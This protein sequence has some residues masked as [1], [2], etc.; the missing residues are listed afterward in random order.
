MTPQIAP[1]RRAAMHRQKGS[2]VIWR[3]DFALA[4]V[5]VSFLAL[6]AG[7]LGADLKTG[8]SIAAITVP[9]ADRRAVPARPTA[10][11]RG[12]PDRSADHGQIVDRLYDE[13]MRWTPS[14]CSP[15][16]N[17]ASMAGKC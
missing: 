3:H 14:G 10:P 11:P 15:T 8:N 9:H 5:G 13:L 16:S 6:S 7:A 2:Q 12:A 1:A 17:Y 4:A